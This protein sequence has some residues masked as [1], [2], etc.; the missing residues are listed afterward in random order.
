MENFCKNGFIMQGRHKYTPHVFLYERVDIDSTTPT[1][2]I[3]GELRTLAGQLNTLS[4]S[5]P[6]TTT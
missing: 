4:S 3:T 2:P 1:I 6:N 5:I